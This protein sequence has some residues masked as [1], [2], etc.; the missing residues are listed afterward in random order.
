MPNT[1]HEGTKMG[2][3]MAE[4]RE[5]LLK[6]AC[7]RYHESGLAGL[8]LDMLA[9]ETGVDHRQAHE[10]FPTSDALVRAVYERAL[11]EMA[12]ESFASLPESGL[13]DQF[14]HLL[15]CRYEFVARHKTGSRH[16]LLGAIGSDGGWRDPFEEQFW[17]FSIQVVALLQAAKRAGEI[18][19]SVDEAIAARAFISYYLTGLLMLLRNDKLDAPAVCDFTFPL[20]DALL[21]SLR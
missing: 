10:L 19:A 4:Q 16:I 9:D 14:K 3:T 18:R 6:A 1:R 5:A 2:G 12:L 13:R 7:S 21:T 15:L 17:R 20:V 11:I 8:D